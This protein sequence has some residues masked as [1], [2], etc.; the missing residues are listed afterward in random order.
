MSQKGLVQP[1]IRCGFNSLTRSWTSWKIVFTRQSTKVYKELEAEYVCVWLSCGVR[2]CLR[3][4]SAR[5]PER[6]GTGGISQLR[7]RLG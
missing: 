6:G 4:L 2:R 5:P 1:S 7:W 3:R